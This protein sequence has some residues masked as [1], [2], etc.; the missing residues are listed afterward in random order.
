MAQFDSPPAMPLYVRDFLGGTSTLHP[1]ERG[2]YTT[3]ICQQWL[4]EAVPGDEPER[5]APLL[6]CSKAEARRIWAGLAGKFVRREDGLW[7]N[8]RCERELLIA[9]AK[10]EIQRAHARRRWRR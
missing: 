5:L 8:R 10:S 3:L 7:I 9:Q 6:G 2:G 1:A 4:G